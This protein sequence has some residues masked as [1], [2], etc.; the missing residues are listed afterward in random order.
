M[1]LRAKSLNER[2]RTL[3]SLLFGKS[4]WKT[5]PLTEESLL[6]PPCFMTGTEAFGHI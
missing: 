4:R 2:F 6:L 5:S 1:E 3:I